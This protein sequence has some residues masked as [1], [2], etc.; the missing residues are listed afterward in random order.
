MHWHVTLPQTTATSHASW[1]AGGPTLSRGLKPVF[2][3]CAQV[4]AP[5]VRLTAPL[6]LLV[7]NLDYDEHKGRIAIGRISS[8]SITKGQSVVVMKPGAGPA[9]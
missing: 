4:S 9:P 7:T 6:Q 8:G 3:C 5:A 1:F 2:N